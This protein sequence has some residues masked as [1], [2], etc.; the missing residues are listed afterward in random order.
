VIKVGKIL[1][2]NISDVFTIRCNRFFL[3][4]TRVHIVHA[5]IAGGVLIGQSECLCCVFLLENIK[6]DS[7]RHTLLRC[8]TKSCKKN[9]VSIYK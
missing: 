8:T 3:A 1:K 4:N 9:Q 7:A 6:F 5:L 2:L